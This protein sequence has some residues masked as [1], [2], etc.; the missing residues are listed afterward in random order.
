M[1]NKKGLWD[2]FSTPV[3]VIMAFVTYVIYN[4]G[5][6]ENMFEKI[7]SIGSLFF[8][9]TIWI[10]TAYSFVR[11][12]FITVRHNLKLNIIAVATTSLL[13]PIIFWFIDCCCIVLDGYNNTFIDVI[14]EAPVLYVKNYFM[15]MLF[16]RI[17]FWFVYCSLIC[18]LVCLGEKYNWL[19]KFAGLF[20]YVFSENIVDI[21]GNTLVLPFDYNDKSFKLYF[22][23]NGKG[24][25]VGEDF[26]DSLKIY[27]EETLNKEPADEKGVKFME[28]LDS[29]IELTGED[30]RTFYFDESHAEMFK[31]KHYIVKEEEG[32]YELTPLVLTKDNETKEKTNVDFKKLFSIS[33]LLPLI[34]FLVLTYELF[35][36]CQSW[37]SYGPDD[38]ISGIKYVSYTSLMITVS[39]VCNLFIVDRESSRKR[40][41]LT[42]TISTLLVLISVVLLNSAYHFMSFGDMFNWPEDVTYFMFIRDDILYH[43]GVG[44][45]RFPA[46]IASYIA[47][48][49][50]QNNQV[51]KKCGKILKEALVESLSSDR[52]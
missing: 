51:V 27:A 15:S 10:K 23:V 3:L 8:A 31:W 7:C 12:K 6:A 49:F 29:A 13:V 46:V 52:E 40:K 20:G 37:L 24:M 50:I 9:M 18:I 21:K 11:N 48:Y 34:I 26:Y 2:I 35:D 25:L 30:K 32:W 22:A 33:F 47:I 42:C 17:V 19:E 39:S 4:I 36:L 5:Y 1:E 45:L 28:L 38:F 14:T 16:L 41:I 43:E 44:A